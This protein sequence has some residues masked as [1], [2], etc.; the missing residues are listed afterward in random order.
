MSNPVIA[1]AA[2]FGPALIIGAV[3]GLG[4]RWCARGLT[5]PAPD[6]GYQQVRTMLDRPGCTW[7]KPVPRS[8]CTC[9]GSCGHIR[10]IG[11]RVIVGG[12]LTPA[13]EAYLDHGTEMPR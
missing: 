4:G 11:G 7:C 13:D 2:I 12:G 5:G 10:C 6:D 8:I 3:I 9:N 1:Y